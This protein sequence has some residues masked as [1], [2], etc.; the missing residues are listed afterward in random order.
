MLFWLRF[1]R[2]CPLS[3]DHIKCAIYAT[4][5]QIAHNH[6]DNHI[7]Q[8]IYIHNDL[9]ISTF[10]PIAIDFFLNQCHRHKPLI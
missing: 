1:A 8:S 6:A 5:E 4:V 2:L 3:V 9:P 10:V 7:Y